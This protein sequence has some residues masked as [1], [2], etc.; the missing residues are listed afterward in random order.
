MGRLLTSCLRSASLP[1]ESAA[2]STSRRPRQSDAGRRMIRCCL[3]CA[4]YGTCVYSVGMIT[5]LGHPPTRCSSGGI[6]VVPRC[7]YLRGKI[8]SWRVFFWV[9]FTCAS[10]PWPSAGV[11]VRAHQ[12]CLSASLFLA[13]MEAAQPET[14]LWRVAELLISPRG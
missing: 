6:G 4:Q 5:G 10:T 2:V 12:S 1:A 14:L 9:C 3:T 7:V 13:Y 11:S 8:G